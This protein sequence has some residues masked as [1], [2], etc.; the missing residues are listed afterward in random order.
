MTTDS[1]VTVQKAENGYIVYHNPGENS[2]TL[3]KV[4]TN[5]DE[6]VAFITQVLKA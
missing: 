6:V 5:V 1:N 3:T 4:F 2:P